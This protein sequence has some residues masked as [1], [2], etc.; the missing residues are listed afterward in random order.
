MSRTPTKRRAG[1]ARS[2]AAASPSDLTPTA[3]LADLR[4]DLAAVLPPLITA[5]AGSYRGFAAA[6]APDDA[7][8]FA[9]HHAACKA[10]LA[11]M[12]MLIKLARWAED[13]TTDEP[14][15]GDADT[16]ERLLASAHSAIAQ[17]E[18]EE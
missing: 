14:P 4:A 9:A 8:G 10:A 2:K 17:V 15:P 3:D 16:L 7:K 13:E 1:S 6:L 11:H 5:A 18:D 12:E